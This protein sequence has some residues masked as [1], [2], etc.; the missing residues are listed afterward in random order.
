[1]LPPRMQVAKSLSV[2]ASL[3]TSPPFFIGD[4]RDVTV[5]L[6]TQ[7][8]HA[9]NIQVSNADGFQEAIP[10]N[11]WTN[12]LTP[13][14]NSTFILT[15]VGARWSRTSSPAGSNATIIFAGVPGA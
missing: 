1:M 15:Q 14:V 13:S 3:I 9:T 11:S 8:A 7:S 6:S 4:L 10:E 12:V 2:N 5:S